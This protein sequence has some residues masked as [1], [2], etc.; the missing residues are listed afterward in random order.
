MK[1]MDLI[2][3]QFLS[4]HEI[5]TEGIDIYDD[6]FGFHQQFDDVI[7]YL[8]QVNPVPEKRL[9]R[10]LIAKIRKHR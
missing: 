8:K 4:Y 9:T 6:A 3:T 10:R 2:S 7:G 5:K 1:P